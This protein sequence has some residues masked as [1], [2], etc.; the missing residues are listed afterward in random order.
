MTGMTVWNL[1]R[2]WRFFHPADPPEHRINSRPVMDRVLKETVVPELRALGFQGSL[3]HFRRLRPD[4]IDLLTFQFGRSGGR[5]VVELA[6]CGPEGYTTSWGK[7]IAPGKVTAHDLT[8]RLRLGGRL[9]FR[10]ADHWFVFDFR[11]YDPPMASSEAQL[12]EDCRKAAAEVLKDYRRQA[13]AW[14]DQ[15][16]KVSREK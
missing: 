14:W 11:Y 13:E 8:D 9:G 5:F 15:Q 10:P 4:R 16:Q 1:F 12:E 3:P 6:Q 2:K 7:K